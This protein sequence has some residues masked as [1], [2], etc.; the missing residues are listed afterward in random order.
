MLKNIA[1]VAKLKFGTGEK[2]AD[3]K[4]IIIMIVVIIM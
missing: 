1:T 2:Q 3:S 4:F